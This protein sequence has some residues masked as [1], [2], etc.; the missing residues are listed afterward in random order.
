MKWISLVVLTLAVSVGAQ[1]TTPKIADKTKGLVKKEGLLT[2]Y[3]DVNNE[4]ILLE[5]PPPNAKGEVGSYLYVEG[6]VG[7]LGSNEIGLDRG[8]IGGTEIVNFKRLAGKLLIEVPNLQYRAVGGSDGERQAVKQS[9]APSIIWAGKVIAQDP[10]GRALV[11]FTSFIIRD[12][13]GVTDTTR[14]QG[15]LTLDKERCTFD[16]DACLAFPENLEFEALLTYQTSTP[17]PEIRR[18]VPDPKSVTLVQHHSLLKLP[19]DGYSP[20]RFDPRSGSFPLTYYD[21]A[22]PLTEPLEKKIISR[23][24]L[25]K[26]DPSAARSKVK[27]PIVYYVDHAAPEPIR[28]AL[29]EGAKWWAEAFDAAGFIDAFRVEILPENAHPLDVRYNVIQWVHRSTRGWSYGGSVVDPRTGEII[30]GHVSLESLRARQDRLIFEGLLGTEKTGTGAKD[31]PI[32]LSLARIRQLSAHE[33]GHT[34]GFA[35]NFAGSTYGGRASVMDYPAPL[36]KLA[37]NKTLDVSDAYGVGLGSWDRHTVAF[38]YSQFPPGSNEKAQLEAIVQKSI[39]QKLVFLTDQ[40]SRSEGG[41]NPLGVLWDNGSDPIRGLVDAMAVRRVALDNFGAHNLPQ[42]QPLS[43]LEQVLVPVYLYHRYQLDGAVKMVG[44]VKYTFAV[45]GDGQAPTSP[46][47]GSRQRT[48]LD[49]VLATL[50]PAE[51]DLS[52]SLMALLGA[53]PFGYGASPE[54]FTR[55]TGPTFDLIGAATTA[56][57]MAIRP[58]LNPER[59]A[60][61]VDMNRR[62]SALPGLD[63]V[64]SKLIAATFSSSSKNARWIEIE[65]AIQWAVVRRLMDLASGS[66]VS[67]GVRSRAMVGLENIARLPGASGHQRLVNSE[68]KRFMDRPFGVVTPPMLPAVAPPGMPIGSGLSGC[69]YGG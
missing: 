47:E 40:D 17:G 36:V 10:D 65:Q 46:I 2:Y 50:K 27:K 57:D 39:D 20:R 22:T 60:R 24:R 3:F 55:T 21:Y 51:L 29:L 61:L 58:L 7:G 28:S 44:G 25:E 23:F 45:N 54:Q 64:I 4:K 37:A 38:A 43:L 48:A 30:K 14:S 9:F 6:L 35:H 18:T 15:A 53:T 52:N 13:H 62:D 12:A 42:D 11:D 41:S 16:P 33:L 56:A 5:I 63:E 31:D 68:I 8:Q 69:S 66:G 19:D 1:D 26:V 67:S 49:T 59:C 32:Q 34:L